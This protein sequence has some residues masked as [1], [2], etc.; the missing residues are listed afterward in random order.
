MTESTIRMNT[1][2]KTE[3]ANMTA[4]L[5][6]IDKRSPRAADLRHLINVNENYLEEP[7]TDAYTANS[8]GNVEMGRLG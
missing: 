7:Y 2:I 8:A 1:R 3:I 6:T 4:E 5:A